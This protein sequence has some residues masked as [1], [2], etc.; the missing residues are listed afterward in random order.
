MGALDA[1]GE[2]YVGALVEDAREV[3][4]A[5]RA[6]NIRVRIMSGGLRPAVLRLGRELGLD[7]M[8]VAAVDLE[9][10]E[11]GAYRQFD[12]NSPLARGGGKRDLLQIWR[13]EL[14]GPLMMVGD[15]ATDLEASDVADVFVAYAGVVARPAVTAAAD[16][17]VHS[18][19]LAPVFVLALAGAAP[20]HAEYRAL[21]EKGLAL[22]DPE[23]HACLSQAK[24]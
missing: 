19:S 3:V 5:L 21:Y 9:F 18:R 23:Y 16:L 10:H 8:D 17:V 14:P 2:Q 1:L 20:R 15:G 13:R 6:E 4:R 22:L 7:G 24:N 11:D 12:V